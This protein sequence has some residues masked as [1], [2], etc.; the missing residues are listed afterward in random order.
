MAQ[1]KSFV[2][3]YRLYRYRPARNLARELAA[4]RESYVYCSPFES[5]NDPMEGLFASSRRL[6]NSNGYRNIREAIVENKARIGICSFSEVYDH[7]LMWAHYAEQFKGIC[8]GYSFSKLLSHLEDGVEFVRMYYDEKVPTVRHNSEP[9]LLVAKKILSCKNYRW[10]YEREWRMFAPLGRVPY[11]SRS[12]V[13]HVYLGSRMEQ[14]QRNEVARSLEGLQ[15]TVSDMTIK[16][17]S[18][19]FIEI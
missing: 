10:L 19:S 7:E 8:I 11:D 15:I 13:T 9:P 4:I 6:R 16:K 12:C 14:E 17:Y 5:L 2:T 1:V 3:P 18:I